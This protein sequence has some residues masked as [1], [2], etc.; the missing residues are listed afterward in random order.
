MLLGWY[1]LTEE[2]KHM[3]FAYIQEAEAWV[4]KQQEQPIMTDKPAS[5]S[6]VNTKEQPLRCVSSLAPGKDFA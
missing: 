4:C 2:E 5:R 3:L 1:F 6:S